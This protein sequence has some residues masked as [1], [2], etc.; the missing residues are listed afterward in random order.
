MVSLSSSSVAADNVEGVEL[1][2]SSLS[3]SPQLAAPF[4]ST[5]TAVG[6]LLFSFFLCF[7]HAF[8]RERLSRKRKLKLFFANSNQASS[9]Y[10]KE[11]SPDTTL[12]LDLWALVA[13]QRRLMPCP[14]LSTKKWVFTLQKKWVFTLLLGC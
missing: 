3:L 14:F 1:S 12:D 4:L 8:S 2:E 10:I 9:D 6:Y 7:F 5:E 13:G 11:S